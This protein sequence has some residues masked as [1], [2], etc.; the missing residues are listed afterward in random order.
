VGIM[1]KLALLGVAG[2]FGLI[3]WLSYK[4]KRRRD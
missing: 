2:I 1:A 4:T 3:A